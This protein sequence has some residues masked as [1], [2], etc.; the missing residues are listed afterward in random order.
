MSSPTFN[1]IGV[2]IVILVSKQW[3]PHFVLICISLLAN[4]AE[5]F[6]IFFGHL[7]F[8]FF[9]KCLFFVNFLKFN[10]LINLQILKYILGK[11]FCHMYA[12]TFSS[13]SEI[14]YYFLVCYIV[15]Y[16]LKDVFWGVCKLQYQ[17]KEK[18]VLGKKKFA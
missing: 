10:S 16:S 17:Q 7:D 4:D 8:V 9:V 14:K 6:F 15:F 5:H 13:I 3:L 12:Y 11:N 1:I 2:F 18:G